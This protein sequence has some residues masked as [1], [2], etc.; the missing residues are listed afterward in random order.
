MILAI[1]ILIGFVALEHIYIMYF[2]MF[3]WTTK[4]RRFF[5]GFPK[6]L[7]EETKVLAANQ[8]LYNGFV[9]LKLEL[10]PLLIIIGKRNYHAI[11]AGMTYQTF[12][13]VL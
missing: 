10:I 5:R 7:F 1:K 9:G 2:E 6:H 13:S 8:G 4:G 11:N 12:N 3:A